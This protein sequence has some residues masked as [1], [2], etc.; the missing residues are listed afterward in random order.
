MLGYVMDTSAWIEYFR[1][2]PE[3][4]QVKEYLFPE[5]TEIAPTITSTLVITEMRSA[6]I[7]DGKEDKF[8]EDLETIR[9]LGKIDDMIEESLAIIAGKRHAGTHTRQNQI[10]YVDCIIWTLAEERNMK[11]LSTDK[12]FKDC[13]HAIY[14]KK[15]G[16]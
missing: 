12:H 10:S 16:K 2:S 3:G 15:E 7:R 11:V 9:W 1:G 8:F 6:Y 14:I 5:P 13:L 4:E